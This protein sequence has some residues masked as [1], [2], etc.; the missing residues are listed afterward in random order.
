MSVNWAKYSTAE[1]AR[2]NARKP[3]GEYSVVRLV[4]GKVRGVPGQTVVHEPLDD[5][6]S[7]SEVFGVKDTEA[8]VK[9][10][11]IH[12]VELRFDQ[13]CVT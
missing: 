3:A 5:N 9:L 11:A 13:T 7:H 4:A 2:E 8:R 12:E 1:E 6:R 10:L